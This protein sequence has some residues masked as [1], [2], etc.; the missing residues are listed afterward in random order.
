MGH[1]K[2]IVTPVNT[3]EELTVPVNN[4]A[5]SVRHNSDMLVKTQAS[6]ARRAQE[7]ASKTGGVISSI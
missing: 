3:V 4:A 7:R 5:E 2:P 6:M 1:L